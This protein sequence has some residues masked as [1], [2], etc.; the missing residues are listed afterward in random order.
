MLPGLAWILPC[1][2]KAGKRKEP[3]GDWSLD[4]KQADIHPHTLRQETPQL[5]WQFDAHF[6]WHLESVISKNYW[7]TLEK[8][9]RAVYLS[10]SVSVCSTEKAYVR[11]VTVKMCNLIWSYLPSFMHSHTVHVSFNSAAQAYIAKLALPSHN[12]PGCH[13]Q[14]WL[15]NTGNQLWEDITPCNKAWWV[16]K[17]AIREMCQSILQEKKIKVW[18]DCFVLMLPTQW[19]CLKKQV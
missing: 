14:R 18:F 15:G 11:S 17:P 6:W 9:L 13:L 12:R 10:S 1:V 19:P 4:A 2:L 5:F 16:C 8:K 7:H 3:M